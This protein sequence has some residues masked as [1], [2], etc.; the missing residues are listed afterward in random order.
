MA[1]LRHSSR[2]IH[3]TVVKYL[4]EQ[5]TALGWIG[6]ADAT[7][8]GATPVDLL[9]SHPPEW[10]QEKRLQAG[11]VAITLGDE[12]MPDLEELGGPLSS[13]EHPIFVD[14]FMDDESIALA[15]ALDVRDIFHGRVPGSKRYLDVLD[16]TTA[17][18]TPVDGWL[19]E[20]DDIT[21]VRPDNAINWQ[22][23]KATAVAYYPEVYAEVA[24]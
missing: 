18:P 8:F 5:L 12:I 14:I 15:L 17:P 2:H 13:V 20:F 4:R 3:Q 9:T 6:P 10:Q 1:Q 11:K 24:E 19:L 21:R 23:V 22:V 7:P 16:F